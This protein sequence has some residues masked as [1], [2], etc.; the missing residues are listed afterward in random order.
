MFDFPSRKAQWQQFA[1]LK[2]I[3][4]QQLCSFSPSMFLILS[5]FFHSFTLLVMHISIAFFERTANKKILF[6]CWQ[7]GEF[8]WVINF[9]RSTWKYLDMI[10][11]CI[12]RHKKIFFYFPTLCYSS[13][14]MVFKEFLYV[15][16]LCFLWLTFSLEF[17]MCFEARMVRLTNQETCDLVILNAY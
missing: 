7:R 4:I 2:F 9:L 15:V 14:E 3:I 10:N 8:F 1:Y 17:W 5:Y 13:N 16:L 6:Y 11:R 12:M